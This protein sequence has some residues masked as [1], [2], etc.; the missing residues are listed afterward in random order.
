M[1]D[2]HTPAL[3]QE[4]LSALVSEPSGIYADVTFG[5]GGHTA[6][7]LS[8]LNEAGRV[9]AFDRDA[10]ALAN[11]I[12][13][14]RLIKIR[15]DF[16][17]LRNH[18]LALAAKDKALGQRISEGLDGILADLGVSSH[19]FDTPERGFSFRAD[20]PLDMRMNREGGPRAAELINTLPREELERI[21]RL[22]GEVENARRVAA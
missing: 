15:S 8:R 9:I 6:G 19:Q 22:Y 7:I 2:Y 10:E 12:E 21:L 16:R 17:F 5:G 18:L 13:D 14:G 20:A 4:S 11:N 3:L 1:S